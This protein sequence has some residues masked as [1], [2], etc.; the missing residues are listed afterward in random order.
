MA[1]TKTC[2]ACD[3]KIAPR[4]Y[5]P[6]SFLK[7]DKR[8]IVECPSCGFSWIDPMPT[9]R[10]IEA[11]Y[12]SG[13][14]NFNRRNEEGKGWYWARTLRAI[15]PKGR[16]LDIGC[17]TGFF[18]SGIRQNCGWEFYGQEMG[19]DAAGYA[20]REL[21]LDVRNKPLERTRFPK[22]FFDFIHFNNVLEHVTDPAVALKEAGRILKPGGT[23]YLAV[24]NGA[25]NRRSFKNYF[26][27]TGQRGAS[28]DGHLLFFSPRSLQALTERSGLRILRTYGTGLKRAFRVLGY[29]PQKKGWEGEFQGRR[30]G[31]SSVEKA[32]EEGRPRPKLYYLFKHGREGLLRFPGLP[33]FTYDYNLYLTKD[34]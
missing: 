13:Y 10:Q 1:S 30:H 3:S 19:R 28:V 8:R 7:G 9:Q 33:S 5:C 26:D 12:H 11:Y 17:A 16:F 21:G 31:E 29:W 6:T 25:V 32:V 23:L 15:K 18:L 22:D 34:A 4:E 14:Y 24:P 20:R 27:A 2:P